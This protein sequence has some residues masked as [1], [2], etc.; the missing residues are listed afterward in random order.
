M[1]QKTSTIDVKTRLGMLRE[2]H[3]GQ[4][5]TAQAATPGTL[6]DPAQVRGSVKEA[7]ER[8]QRTRQALIEALNS[9]PKTAQAQQPKTASDANVGGETG[10]GSAQAE[11]LGAAVMDGMLKRASQYRKIAAETNDMSAHMYK[12]AN[13]AARTIDSLLDGAQKTATQRDQAS[14]MFKVA[15]AAA[16]MMEQMIAQQAAAVREPTPKEAM[17]HLHKVSQECFTLGVTDIHALLGA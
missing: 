8:T 1:S 5:K 14:S 11:M 15:S 12:I 2:M 3:A 9:A 13:A 10:V 7:Q 16:S 17:D 4:S 6:A